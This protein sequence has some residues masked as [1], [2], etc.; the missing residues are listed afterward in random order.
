M[1]REDWKFDSNRLV[2]PLIATV[3]TF[4]VLGAK[5]IYGDWGIAWNVGSYLV[6]LASLLIVIMRD[7]T[8][9]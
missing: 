8:E 4:M 2:L 6:A 3:L 5:L 9:V 7:R 1:I